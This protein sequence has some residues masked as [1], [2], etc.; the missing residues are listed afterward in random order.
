MPGIMT[1]MID[2]YIQTDPLATSRSHNLSFDLKKINSNKQDELAESTCCPLRNL[3][4]NTNL[5]NAQNSE[6]THAH[7]VISIIYDFMNTMC[8]DNIKIPDSKCKALIDIRYLF[9]SQFKV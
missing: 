5:N 4:Q 3:Q 8:A 2:H 6:T 1:E 9:L 7:E